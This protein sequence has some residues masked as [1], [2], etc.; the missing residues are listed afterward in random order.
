LIVGD[1]QSNAE[2]KDEIL[3]A[4]RAAAPHRFCNVIEK[5]TCSSRDRRKRLEHTHEASDVPD[6]HPSA[7]ARAMTP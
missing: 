2:S 3:T 6:H 5:A 4:V 7:D 1:R